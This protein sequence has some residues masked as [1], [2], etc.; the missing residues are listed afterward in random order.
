MRRTY[1][2]TTI[3]LACEMYK[4]GITVRKIM[5]ELNISKSVVNRA[6]RKRNIPVNKNIPRTK[7]IRKD[8]S[9]KITEQSLI[10]LIQL[11]SD[12]IG[13]KFLAKE[14]KC[15]EKTIRDALIRNNIS[16]KKKKAPITK[17]QSIKIID[18]YNKG[19]SITLIAKDAG[20]CKS[21]VT[22]FLKEK[23]IFKLRK[24]ETG[25]LLEN[26]IDK[27][28]QLYSE[29]TDIKDLAKEYNCCE[30]TI[31]DMFHKNNVK[32]RGR[33]L[34]VYSDKSRVC[35]TCRVEKPLDDF[36]NVKGLP[37]GKAFVC[38][39]CSKK[40]RA[41]NLLISTYGITSVQYDEMFTN[42]DGLCYIC[43]EREVAVDYRS[44]NVKFLAVDH[45][46]KTGKI[47]KLLCWKCNTTL[48]R[49]KEDEEYIKS[50]L[51]YVIEHK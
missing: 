36:Y 22:D 51:N 19:I 7:P 35:C 32:L 14:F 4:K 17:E 21:R 9:Y 8:T 29:G 23:N 20:A 11:Y 1:S 18:L 28:I 25:T 10:N 33:K 42:Q 41:N 49:L 5:E 16:V 31:R 26:N 15:S 6:L 44:G 48:G 3:E 34:K 40:D 27:I 30:K 37:H 2:E 50:F 45:D 13:I 38:K 24:R 39:E 12:G 43:G 47:R 46:H